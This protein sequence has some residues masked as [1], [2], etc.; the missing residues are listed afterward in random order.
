MRE[1]VVGMGGRFAIDNKMGTKLLIE[2]PNYSEKAAAAP[3]VT[4]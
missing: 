1:R 4:Q 2:L 3:C